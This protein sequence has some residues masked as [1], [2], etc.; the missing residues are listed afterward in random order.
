MSARELDLA[1][2]LEGSREA[3]RW[4]LL[5]ID[6][7]A[8]EAAVAAAVAELESMGVDEG[9][10]PTWLEL[11]VEGW[12]GSGGPGRQLE[13]VASAYI[14]AGD[15]DLASLLS[16]R[17][18]G[19][20]RRLAKEP[21]L[22]HEGAS[23]LLSHARLVALLASQE[24]LS[25]AQI[26]KIVATRDTR[27]PVVWKHIDVI[28][29]KLDI[30]PSLQRDDVEAVAAVDRALELEVFADAEEFVCVEMVADAGRRLGFPGD[31]QSALRT[32]L[33][34]DA[35]PKGPYL[36]ML[37][38]QCVLAEFY[39]HD[40]SA[41]YEFNPR[42]EAS[43]WLFAQYPDALE[44][45]G[46]PFLN[47]AK[48]VDRLGVEWA[49]SK[50]AARRAEA[51]ALVGI[52]EGLDSMGFAARRELASWIR[53]ILTRQIR[54]AEGMSIDLPRA[55]TST[56]AGRMIGAVG[57]EE[58][59]TR[60]I[61]EQRLVDAACS[62]RHPAPDWISRGLT[63]SVNAT[64]VSRMKCGD[65]DFQDSSAHKVVAY[66]AHAGR[67]TDLYLH[68]HLRTLGRILREREREWA[69][70]VGP[71]LAWTVKVVFVAHEPDLRELPVAQDIGGVEVEVEVLTF[72]ELLEELDDGDPTV[73]TALRN[74]VLEPLSRPRTPDAVRQ[75]LL[76]MISAG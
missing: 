47:N 72:A 43:E 54:L 10:I 50:D 66:E 17:Y 13:A 14:D 52:I 61:L 9:D 70:N 32:L 51:H 29:G 8:E 75:T 26:A 48:S 5:P 24:S 33:P 6:V 57:A 76:G 23:A 21:L 16:E 59:R 67:L 20:H 45:A 4:L 34:A 40:L 27:T 71:G 74:Y 11:E 46:N 56:Q 65:C 42:G 73:L 60:G 63:D 37:H 55:L 2:S 25:A 68:A 49:R 19:L 18:F 12:R 28:L 30:K 3:L 38:F 62:L 35:V 31:L 44:V 22:G 69:E 58:T 41:I 39:D 64:N 53:R 15:D 1:G 7:G 36:Q